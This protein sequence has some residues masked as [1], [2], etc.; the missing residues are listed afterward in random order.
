VGVGAVIALIGMALPWVT[1]G[2]GLFLTPI[3]QNGFD[4]TGILVFVS[5]ILL[6]GLLTLPYASRSGTSS[7]DRP[8]TYVGLAT[9]GVIALIIQLAGFFGR[10]QLGF[11]DRAPG[12]WVSGF[13]LFVVCWGVGELLGE[14]PSTY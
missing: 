1:V 2:E 9:L 7:L 6:L 10:G 14:R 4:G 5:A 3:R 11:P 8:W 13:G 12:L